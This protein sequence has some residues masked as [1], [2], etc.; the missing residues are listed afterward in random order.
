MS[1][2]AEQRQE[3]M[4]GIG[5]S[6]AAAACGISKW[7]TPVQLWQE[8]TRRVEPPNLDDKEFIQWGNIL[9]DTICEE[10]ARRSGRK[11]RRVNQARADKEFP[12]M[13][14]NIDRDVVGL[15]EGMEAKNSSHWMADEWGDDG[16]DE[17]P[18]YY[19]IQGTHYMRVFDYEAWN[20]G[21]LLGGNELRSY[22]ILRN[23]ET[24]KSL[25]ELESYFWEC[26]E[27]DTAPE[28]IVVD[29]LQRINPKGSGHIVATDEIA[30]KVEA[31]AKVKAQKKT[32]DE[33]EKQL[34][35]EIG[36]FMGDKSELVLPGDIAKPIV[37]FRTGKRSKFLKKE[38]AA[39]KDF[40]DLSQKTGAE[41]IEAFTETGTGRTF[42][43]K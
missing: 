18:L 17:V 41:L 3:R 4:Q 11:V 16:T 7:K 14:A 8:K 43:V 13:R 19:L 15:R 35:L 5:G 22:R 6:D 26:V 29:D 37:T 23:E 36:K 30:G 1:L 25:I 42:L 21:V 39:V 40:S 12:F 27:T 10:W 24:E 2:T 32:Y 28:A 33:S 31:L 34:I 9:E 38:L 20:F